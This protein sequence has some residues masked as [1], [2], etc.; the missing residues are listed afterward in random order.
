MKKTGFLKKLKLLKK[1][2]PER[3]KLLSKLV[4][5]LKE[6]NIYLLERIVFYI[7]ND[8]VYK[9]FNE[10][11]I[12]IRNGGYPTEDSTRLKSAGGIFFRLIRNQIPHE[13][14]KRIWNIQRRKKKKERD[15]KLLLHDINKNIKGDKDDEYEEG[16]LS[17]EAILMDDLK[18]MYL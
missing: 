17:E 6:P 15:S 4:K 13:E 2:D 18:C 1:D 5:E 7:P 10:T 8:L 11:R 3:I 14:Y 16:E 9:V 12:I